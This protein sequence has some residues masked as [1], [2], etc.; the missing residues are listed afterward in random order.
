MP[1]RNPAIRRLGLLGKRGIESCFE[2]VRVY[3]FGLEVFNEI[4]YRWQHDFRREWQRRNR[5]PR[6]DRTVIRTV[7]NSASDVV[8]K[9]P[10]PAFHP[11]CSWPRSVTGCDSPAAFAVVVELVR[12]ANRIL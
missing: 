7:R 1:W 2:A 10:L 11:E 3:L 8:V 9:F 12:I 5:R 4:I 6:S